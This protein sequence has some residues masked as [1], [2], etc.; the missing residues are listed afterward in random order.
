MIYTNLNEVLSKNVMDDPT[1]AIPEILKMRVQDT[2]D[3]TNE[4]VEQSKKLL[5]EV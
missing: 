1:Y 5:G 2:I 3:K 4:L